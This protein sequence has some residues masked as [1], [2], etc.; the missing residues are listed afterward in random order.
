MSA[1]SCCGAPKSVKPSDIF[2]P[3]AGSV[4]IPRH[5]H[6]HTSLGAAG[7]GHGESCWTEH[8]QDRNTARSALAPLL[9]ASLPLLPDVLIDSF[10]CGAVCGNCRWQV[11]CSR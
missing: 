5:S 2:H 6:G 7:C 3:P 4:S 11:A 1:W 9:Q 10:M 8:R